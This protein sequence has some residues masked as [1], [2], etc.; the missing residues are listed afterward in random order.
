MFDVVIPVYRP[1]KELEILLK[2]LIRQKAPAD[3]IILINTGKQ[4]FDDS[5][6]LISDKIEVHHISSDE[7]DHGATRHMGMMLSTADY[8]LFMTMDAIPADEWMTDRL[9]EAFKK[10]VPV[11][12]SYAR[13]LPKKN[14]RYIERFTRAFN[15]PD[16]E[17]IKTAASKDELGIKTY[18]CSDVCA[19]YDRKIYIKNGGFQ[20]PIIFNEDMVYA[21]KA[22]E[23]GYAIVYAAKAAVY[24]SHNYGI[25]EQ[26]SR[27]FDMGVSQTDYREIFDSVKSESEGVKLV[28]S[29][30]KYLLRTGHWYDVP[31][32]IINSAAKYLGYKAGR[33]YKKLSKKT[34]L[35]FTMN[36]RYWDKIK[37]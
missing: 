21:A 15:Y 11:A 32:L 35:K 18:F 1:G 19:M 13:Q 2:R 3:R 17:I 4:Y 25:K 24:H 16:T 5:R 31:Y 33:N 6:Y 22:V 7:F 23:Y 9:L 26:F 10:D 28:F 29:C 12:V 14:C 30:I 37:V 36:K 27:N 20:H 34:I 8:V